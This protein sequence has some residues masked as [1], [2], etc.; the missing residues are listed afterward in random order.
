MPNDIEPALCVHFDTS[1]VKGVFIV[2]ALLDLTL[3]LQIVYV[4]IY[5]SMGDPM[6]LFLSFCAARIRSNFTIR[7]FI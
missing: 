2:R 3:Q 4:C 1:V 6:S 7:G 5:V